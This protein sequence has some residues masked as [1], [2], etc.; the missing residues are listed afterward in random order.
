MKATFTVR[1]S[2]GKERALELDLEPYESLGEERIEQLLA[3]FANT[4]GVQFRRALQQAVDEAAESSR[5]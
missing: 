5:H 4:A 1:L 2:N 3:G